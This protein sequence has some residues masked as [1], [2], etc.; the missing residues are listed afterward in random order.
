MGVD[1]AW[2]LDWTSNPA[3]GSDPVVGE[4]DSHTFPPYKLLLERVFRLGK[5]FFCIYKKKSN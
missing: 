4:F 1:W 5:L 3:C 2:W